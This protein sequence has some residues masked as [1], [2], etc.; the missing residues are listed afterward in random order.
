MIYREKKNYLIPLSVV[1]V[2]ILSLVL[3]QLI[4]P[5]LNIKTYCQ[6]YPEE[7]WALT[8][9]NNGQIISSMTNY[10]RGH[11]VQYSLNQF[12]RGEFISL[13]FSNKLN[14]EG[15]I[16]K[17][18]T[19]A[20]IISSE[21]E[22]R[23]ISLIGE[24]DVAKSNLKTK[25]AGQKESV[26]KEAENKLRYTEEKIKEQKVLFRRISTLYAKGL[27]SEEE[28]ETHK[29]ALDLLEIEEQ[30]YKSQL[31][32]AST[33]EKQEE[34]NLIESRINSIKSRLSFLKSRKNN[35]TIISPLSGYSVNI[36]SAD[37]LIKVINNKELIL[38]APIKVEDIDMI[39][40]GQTL[41]INVSDLDKEFTGLIVSVSPEVKF[42]N[43]RQ[44]IFVSIKIDNN[45]G[46]LLPGM[47]KEINLK[48]K[49]IKFSN[50]IIRFF[51]T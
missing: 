2:I 26:I 50:Y 4:H 23:L 18:D 7:E 9:G 14:N 29:W 11:T 3:N 44:V 43:N 20:S 21:V 6:L 36:F 49:Q 25:N 17:G 45:E 32:N 31:E 16:N 38:K 12:E 35:L 39:K 48:I 47:V 27:S 5:V 46:K 1:S 13:K 41:I 34:I 30:I 40:K 8:K 33:G 19:I 22:D 37:T 51:T 10:E 42:L 15:F 28:Y 24:L